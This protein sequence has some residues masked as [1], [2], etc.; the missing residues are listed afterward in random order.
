VEEEAETVA[1]VDV[2]ATI[3]A[4]EAEVEDRTMLVAVKHRRVD[5]VQLLA[6]MCLTMDRKVQPTR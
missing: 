5:F 3:E 1:A 4:E 2:A 6:T